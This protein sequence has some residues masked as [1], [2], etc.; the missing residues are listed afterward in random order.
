MLAHSVGFA[1]AYLAFG[2][3]LSF[4]ARQGWAEDWDEEL[5][6]SALGPPLF[7]LIAAAV[8]AR[9]MWTRV[10]PGRAGSPSQLTC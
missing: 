5:L 9:F 8:L 2:F 10:G 6:A 1:V 3:V 4:L 7:T